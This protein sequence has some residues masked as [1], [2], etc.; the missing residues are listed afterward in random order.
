MPSASSPAARRTGHPAGNAKLALLNASVATESRERIAVLVAAIVA[1]S[2]SYID[3]TA[4]IVAL[5]VIKAKLPAGDAQAQWIIEGYLLFLSALILIGGALGDR[6]G[7]RRLFA[8]GVWIFALSS[9][10][11]A[12]AMQPGFLI[13]A[14]CVQGAGAALMIPESLALITAAY[15]A[16]TRGRAIGIW[17]AASAIT[18]AA[19]PVLG[20]WLTQTFSWRWVFWINIPLAIGVLWLVYLRVPENRAENVGGKPDLAGS[21]LV[22][23]ALGL[24]VAGLMQMQQ[25]LADPSALSLLI[26][27]GI[28]FAAFVFVERRASAPIVP[29]HLFASR[30]FTVASIYT[31]LLYAALGGALFFVPF[32][33][34]HIMRYTPLDAGLA[35]LPAIVLIAAGSPVSGALAT[36]TGTRLTLVAGAG[37]AALGFGLFAKLGYGASYATSV[38]PA[39][40]VLGVGLAV[41]VAPLVTAVMGAA[42]ADD[43]GAASGVNNS[44]SRIGNLVAIAVLGIVIAASGAGPMPTQAHPEGFGHA[45][46]GAAAMSLLAA[47]VAMLFPRGA[48][49]RRPG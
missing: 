5:P 21:A 43:V 12:V 27:G 49:D 11:C 7:R 30:S 13:V 14:R 26:L 25:R 31:F 23:V 46:L 29:L 22:T 18:M 35:L 24:M 16:R 20:G 39:T 6:Y 17:A 40:I 9:V 8:L 37:I 48:C 2:M 32:E 10:A 1:S 47:S 44:I 28:L 38:L 45:M 3:S 15:D 4:L 33:L 36:R 34:Q 42:D 41:A 19:G